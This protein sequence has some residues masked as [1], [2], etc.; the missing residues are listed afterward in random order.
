MKVTPRFCSL[1]FACLFV[2]LLAVPSFASKK[3]PVTLQDQLEFGVKMAQRG[4]WSEALFRFR[5][6]ERLA[7]ESPSVL[8]NLAVA[9]EALGRFEEALEIYRRALELDPD[10]AGLRRNYAR[11]VEFYQSFKPPEEGEGEDADGDSQVDDAATARSTSAE[12]QSPN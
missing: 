2:G 1:A 8:N 5:Q 7:P 11:F 4:L 6:A 3:K 12:T 9:H 10:N